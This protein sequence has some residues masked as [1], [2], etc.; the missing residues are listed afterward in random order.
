MN[1]KKKFCPKCGQEADKL[2]DG[3][4]IDCFFKKHSI[5]IPKIVVK[6]C[7][8]CGRYFSG[9]MASDKLTEIIDAEIE[10]INGIKDVHYKIS[11]GKVYISLKLEFLGLQKSEEHKIA[12]LEKPIICQRCAMIGTKY[13][14]AIL[15]I[16]AP[17]LI[18]NDILDT[19]KKKISTSRSEMAFISQVKRVKGGLD[20]YIGSKSAAAKAARTVKEK[21]KRF[22]VKIKVTRK[23]WGRKRG[24]NVYRDTILIILREKN[25]NGD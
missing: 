22:D 12:I 23:L 2:L 6:R 24:K 8:R 9:K 16:R 18:V 17:D 19:V 4:C 21:F 1:I 13:Y 25:N 11:N 10:K 3:M 20:V 5:E 15:Q 7:K 14:N